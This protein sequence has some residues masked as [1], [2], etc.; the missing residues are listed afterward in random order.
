MQH[1]E[2]A[3]SKSYA[4]LRHE[5]PD[6]VPPTSVH[7]KNA[8]N[9]GRLLTNGAG[10]KRPRGDERMDEDARDVKRER[11]A[12]DADDSDDEEMEIEDDDEQQQQQTGSGKQGAPRFPFGFVR[13]RALTRPSPLPPLFGLAQARYRRRHSRCRRG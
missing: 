8:P 7:V 13:P 10:E 11:T 4:T 9:G 2:Y 6:F 1:I 5:D 12:R 3:K